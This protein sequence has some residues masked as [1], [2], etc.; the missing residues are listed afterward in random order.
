[1]MQGYWLTSHLSTLL[2]NFSHLRKRADFWVKLRGDL[3]G[4]TVAALIAVPYGMAL[5]VAMGMRPEV[6]LYTS[7]IGGLVAGF[8]SSSPVLISGLSATAVPILGAVTKA[9][10]VRMLSKHTGIGIPDML[11]VGDALFEGGN[12]EVVKETGI[13]TH[14]VTGPDE[15]AK[16]IEEI[17]A[18]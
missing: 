7:I 5:S 3:F 4:G 1:M 13:K 11:Y 12:D 16:V 15:T 6:G 8:L 10:G 9:Y 18:V 2:L 17:L 14:Q